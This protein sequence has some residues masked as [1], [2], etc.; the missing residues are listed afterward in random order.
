MGPAS[1]IKATNHTLF[2]SIAEKSRLT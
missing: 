1:A 2:E